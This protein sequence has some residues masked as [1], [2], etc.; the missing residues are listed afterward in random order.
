MSG[1]TVVRNANW[2]K[3]LWIVRLSSSTSMMLLMLASQRRLS[4]YS[5]T[6]IFRQSSLPASNSVRCNFSPTCL[7]FNAGVS[8]I[9]E[10][11]FEISARVVE[12]K[13]Y[14]LSGVG[15]ALQNLEAWIQLGAEAGTEVATERGG[16]SVLHVSACVRKLRWI[17]GDSNHRNTKS[18]NLYIWSHRRCRTLLKPCITLVHLYEHE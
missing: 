15:F 13:R 6:A 16:G 1:V 10:N 3:S 12:E 11:N 14:V 5:L 4:C 8:G 18:W 17:C 2:N 9:L 7:P